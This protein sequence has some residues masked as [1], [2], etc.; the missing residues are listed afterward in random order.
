MKRKDFDFRMIALSVLIFM[1]LSVVYLRFFESRSL[2]APAKDIVE[3]PADAGLDF[4]R[5]NLLSADGTRLTGWYV[6]ARRSDGVLYFL[7][8]NGGN[9]SHRLEKIKFF[10]GLGWPVFILD[11]RGYGTSSGVPGEEGLY[12]DAVAGYD[13]LLKVKRL[14]PQDILVYGESLGTAVAVELARRVPVK[15]L[16]LEGG[17][18]SIEDMGRLFY[19]WLPS[20]LIS[21]KYDSLRKIADVRVPVLFIHS[22]NDEVVPFDMG[23][24]LYEAY[25]GEKQFVATT[26]SHNDHFLNHQ[27]RLR[28]AFEGYLS[29][30]RQ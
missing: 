20:I 17:F 3:T 23:R 25:P 15:G 12:K 10:H 24:R 6:E 5:V 28:D 26:G 14:R 29:K 4:Q 9:I 27:A 8:G 18:T 1:I 7:H 21:S 11:Y 30:F 16:V 22:R 2:Y 13:Y 19:P